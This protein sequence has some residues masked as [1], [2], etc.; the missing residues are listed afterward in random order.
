[1]SAILVHGCAGGYVTLYLSYLCAFIASPYDPIFF[2]AVLTTHFSPGWIA[3][4]F[5]TL[6]DVLGLTSTAVSGLFG[7]LPR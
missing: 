4:L 1:M 2:Y 5:S 6:L 7:I 3:L